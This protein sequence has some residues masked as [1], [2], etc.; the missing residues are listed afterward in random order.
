MYVQKI[1]CRRVFGGSRI[2]F[3]CELR[4]AQRQSK[5][6]PDIQHLPTA[7]ATSF[8][9]ISDEVFRW[10]LEIKRPLW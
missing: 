10:E 7:D 3:L 5:E 2:L 6:N 9:T 4:V 1:K 8:A